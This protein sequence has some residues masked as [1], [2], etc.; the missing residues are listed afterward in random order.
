[1]PWLFSYGTLQLDLV[2][3]ATFGRLLRGHADALPGFTTALVPIAN[4]EDA[5]RFG[6]THYDN[7]VSDSRPGSAVA[8]TVFEVTDAELAA[9]D[10]YERD[11]AYERIPAVLASGQQ[12]WVYVHRGA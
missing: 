11:A 5:R 6:R 7:V 10:D 4:A 12:A 2:Q 9:A 1:M 3:L 8:G